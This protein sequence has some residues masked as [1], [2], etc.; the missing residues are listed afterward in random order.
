MN[1]NFAK[2][3]EN[4]AFVATMIGTGYVILKL[5]KMVSKQA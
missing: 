1:E 4:V 3:V 2:V 5:A